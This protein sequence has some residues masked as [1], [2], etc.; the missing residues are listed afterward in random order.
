MLSTG[1]I[2]WC[3]WA[4][5]V[6]LALVSGVPSKAQDMVPA[7]R[8]LR[9][10]V[11][12]SS[13]LLISWKEPKGDFDS[14]LFLYNSVPGGQ[15]REIIVSKS[16][17]KVLITDFNPSK[18]YIVSV[19]AVS[20]TVQSRPLQGR[21]KAEGGENAGGGKTEPQRQ[22]Q[23][24]A[25]PEDANEIVGALHTGLGCKTRQPALS[26]TPGGRSVRSRARGPILHCVFPIMH[27]VKKV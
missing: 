19:S 27:L 14:Y 16:D 15:Q 11:L 17:T 22:T 20:G 24:V 3:L 13:K 2:R 9:F 10:K 4:P 7:P 6:L 8:R 5:L 1:K 25:P 21:Y 18:D 26:Q 23:S 12:S